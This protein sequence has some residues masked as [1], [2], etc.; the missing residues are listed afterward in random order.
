VDVTHYV[1]HLLLLL[2]VTLY[3][4]K[5]LLTQQLLTG[6]LQARVQS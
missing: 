5:L 1:L 3:K 2:P 6:T 4:Q